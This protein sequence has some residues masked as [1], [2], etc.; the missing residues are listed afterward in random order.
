MS[1]YDI[2]SIAVGGDTYN[3]KPDNATQENDGLMSSE[4]KQKLDSMELESITSSEI[5]SIFSRF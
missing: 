5:S 1:T 4:D 2:N 3:I